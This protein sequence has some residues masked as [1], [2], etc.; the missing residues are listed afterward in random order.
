MSSCQVEVVW[1]C[2]ISALQHWEDNH[3]NKFTKLQ[4]GELV[5]RIWRILFLEISTRSWNWSSK[6]FYDFYQ[7][8]QYKDWM[9]YIYFTMLNSRN[10]Y[11]KKLILLIKICIICWCTVSV[12]KIRQST[13]KCQNT[14]LLFTGNKMEW[15]I[16]A[17]VPWV[18]WHFKV[19]RRIL[20]TL[21]VWI[22]INQH[23]HMCLYYH[24]DLCKRKRKIT[25][26]LP[27]FVQKLLL[28]EC[29]KLSKI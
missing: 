29:S 9:I 12:S 25:H 1:E 8:I 22:K 28:F 3:D 13:L 10:E 26:L 24:Y 6:Y 18:F 16:F 20:L 19:D 11:V 5:T 23:Q 17:S 14:L 7:Y 27:I 4:T 2:F 21:T 15:I